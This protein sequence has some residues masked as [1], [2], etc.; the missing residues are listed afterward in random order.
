MSLNIVVLSG[1]LGKDPEIKQT[2]GGKSV[3]SFSIAVDTGF[4]QSKKTSW[5]NVEV[6]D[7][8]A[9][10]VAKYVTSG[11]RVSVVGSL[12]EDTWQDS[13]TG[14]KRSKIKVNASRVDIIDFADKDEPVSNDDIPF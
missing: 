5:F 8:T 6:W 3:A 4:G 11:K 13:S 7:K 2:S 14:Q 1:R 12:V 9:E 10:A